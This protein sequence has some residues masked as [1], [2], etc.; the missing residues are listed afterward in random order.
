MFP[1]MNPRQMKRMMKQMGMAMEELDAREVVI[2][3]EDR[4]IVIKN[5][6]VSVVKV[7]NQKTYQVMGEEQEVQ[8]IPEEDVKMVAEKA[9]VGLEEAREALES[10]G[11]DLAE[12]I[13]SLASKGG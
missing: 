13:M 9:G 3:L 6:T 5:P 12:A 11:G 7:Q 8:S 1:R 4:E 2:K 10:S